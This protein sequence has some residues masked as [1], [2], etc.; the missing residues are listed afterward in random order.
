MISLNKN[1]TSIYD[2]VYAK[3]NT[4]IY[5]KIDYKVYVYV[6]N[7][8]GITGSTEIETVKRSIRYSSSKMKVR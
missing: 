1:N 8:I 4:I 3:V 7:T 6:N 5:D 2:K